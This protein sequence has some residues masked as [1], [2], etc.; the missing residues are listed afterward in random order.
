[1]QARGRGGALPP[2]GIALEGD[3]GHRIDAVLAIAML[4]GLAARSEARSIAL[5]LSRPSLKAAQLADVIAGFYASRPPTAGPAMIGMP[6]GSGAASDAPPAAGM[7]LKTTPDGTSLYTSQIDTVIDTADNAVLIRNMLLA[8]ND[9]NAAIVLAGP[10]TGLARMLGLY[11]APPQIQTKVRHLV[12]AIGAFPS[13]APDPAIAADV[14]AARTLFAEWPTPIVAVGAEVGAALPYPGAAI[15]TGMGWVAAHPV[16]DAYRAFGT[17]PYDAPASA[18][19]ATLYAAHADDGYFMLS[20]PGTIGVTDDGRTTFTPGA[21]GRHRYLIVDPAQKE[22]VL[23]LYV[24][25]VSSRPIPRPSRGRGAPP[26]QQQQ[27]QQ[28]Q[29]PPQQPAPNVPPAAQPPAP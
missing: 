10:A 17:M 9:A 8:Q 29:A 13:S 24:E 19:A 26:A 11:G 22:R 15:E 3:L 21:G 28:Q 14:A 7:L 25:T 18:L 23:N 12:V 1:M 6:E 27:Q 16:A 5:A 20:E 4:N 2:I